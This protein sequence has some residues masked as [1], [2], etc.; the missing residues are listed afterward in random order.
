[1]S[2]I[3]IQL[4]NACDPLKPAEEKYYVDLTDVRGG[5]R[6]IERTCADINLSTDTY[7]KKLFTGHKGCGKSTELR[8]LAHTLKNS[9]QT[10]TGKRYF[11]IYMDAQEH[12][13]VYDAS[14]TDILL[15]LVTVLAQEL[16]EEGIELKDSY[17]EKRLREV[18]S[19]LINDVE[20]E[21]AEITAGIL[22]TSLK[23]KMTSSS[24]RDKIRKQVEPQ[25]SSLF[26]EINT[27]FINAR[28]K[29]KTHKPSDGGDKYS[30]FVII[31]DN[32]EKIRR[33][34]GHE[35]EEASFKALFIE[36]SDRFIKLEAHLI[37]TVPL[38]LV[39]SDGAKLTSTYGKSPEVL[40]NVKVE[41]RLTQKPW[42]K[43]RDKLTKLL[44]LRVPD[45]SIDEIFTPEAL[46]FLL[47]Y[48]G[49][50]VR[51][52]M[53]FAREAASF[54]KSTPIPFEAAQKAV[55][56]IVPL[57]STSIR[58]EEWPLLAALELSNDQTWDSNQPVNRS[59]LERLCVLEYLN[60][61]DAPSNFNSM[62]PW[63]A[64]FPVV[65]ELA[66]FK[67]AVKELK[68]NRSKQAR[69]P[70]SVQVKKE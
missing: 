8:Q 52:L 21:K 36:D 31:F 54:A 19:I 55:F 10:P 27:L 57:Y 69:E 64:V 49:G 30:D 60:G 34:H 9:R 67:N 70:K 35:T 53:G 18:Q 16:R 23:F 68:S 59:L 6:I 1:M 44:N 51:Q 15:S 26:D 39:R 25:M 17:L 20:L 48:S 12:V 62:E 5:T 11:P 33:I 41:T 63:Y 50:H 7:L 4:Y 42:A 65:R 56:Q 22:K 29:L 14:M 46:N 13:D 66:Q 3:L 2:D 24:N 32:L 45:H 37:I 38:E 47:K 43:G 61:E 40:P 28:T 58:E